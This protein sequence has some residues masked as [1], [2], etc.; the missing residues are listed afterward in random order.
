VLSRH[1]LRKM[2]SAKAKSN[3]DRREAELVLDVA[4]AHWA[5]NSAKDWEDRKTAHDGFKEAV[6]KLHDFLA[7]ET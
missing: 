5:V 6:R 3:H 4:I 1:S 7:T 2:A